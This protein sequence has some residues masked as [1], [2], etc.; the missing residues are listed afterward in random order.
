M[1]RSLV[2]VA[3][4]V[5]LLS[6]GC[7]G[8]LAPNGNQ[9]TTSANAPVVSITLN[10][11]EGDA[12]FSP[13]YSFS[14]HDPNNQLVL[15]ELLMDG[16]VYAQG[17]NQDSVF[18]P[19]YV[20]PQFYYNLTSEVGNHTI[21]IL[22]ENAAGLNASETVAFTVLPA[23]EY[24]AP[25]WYVCNGKT[26]P[27]CAS[28][29]Q[30]YCDKFDPTDISVREAASEAIAKD[31]GPFSINQLLDIYDWVHANIFYQNVPLTLA[32]PYYPNQTLLT[33]SGDCKNQAVLIASMVEA[34]G[35]SARV[36][37][38]PDCEHAFAEVYIGNQSNLDVVNSAVWAHYPQASGQPINWHTSTNA[39]NQTE[40][41]MI[42]DTAGGCFPGNTISTCLNASQT[43][44]LDDCTANGALRAPQVQGTEFGPKTI[45]NVTQAIQGGYSQSYWY[46]PGTT[47]PSQYSY[48]NF[49]V[50]VQSLSPGPLSWY[51]T[52]ETD[53]SSF[54]AGRGFSYYYGEENVYSGSYDF[55]WNQSGRVYFALRNGNAQTPITATVQVVMT[56]Y[57]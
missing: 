14:C 55:N 2:I 10:S 19:G 22:A 26:D 40:N 4:L 39:E 52:D 37:I 47:I 1:R 36:L 24:T 25:G 5:F 3:V 28:I 44:E 13:A 57:K 53:D 46:D 21:E 54:M 30:Y 12:P 41:W 38:I 7:C 11:S 9:T 34:I 35:G 48:C 56:C 15:C 23:A 42:F 17:Q 27:H 50:S 18:P 33:K 49:N 51:V 16:Q 45:I 8:A 31:P 6:Y 29:Q 43:F 32:P 20:K